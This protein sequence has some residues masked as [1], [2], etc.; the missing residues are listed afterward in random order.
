[1]DVCA[2]CEDL[3]VKIKNTLLFY[4]TTLMCREVEL[5]IHK[6][7]VDKLYKSMQGA[8]K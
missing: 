8:K 5:N 7:R 1:M 2:K 3:G 4:V 6:R